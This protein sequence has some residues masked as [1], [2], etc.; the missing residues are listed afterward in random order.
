MVA[1]MIDK[2]QTSSKDQILTNLKINSGLTVDELAGILDITPMGV[3]QHL[4][5]MEREELV[6]KEK[7]RRPVGRPNF[8]YS[9]TEKAEDLFPK[10][11]DDFVT[12]ILRDIINIDGEEK[13][14]AIFEARKNRIFDGMQY[15]FGQKKL[16]DRVNTL[17]KHLNENDHFAVVCKEKQDIV[18]TQ[19]NCPL[20]TISREFPYLCQC[21]KDLY[22]ELLV[23][24]VSIDHSQASGEKSC[25]FLIR[26]KKPVQ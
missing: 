2:D 11:Y 26:S 16:I 7:N 25:R 6:R 19:Y 5:L 10:S 12:G 20:L 9:L 8:K 17:S 15:R 23:A 21:E 1:N 24:D 14:E 13:V 4:A 18:L 22:R 3:R